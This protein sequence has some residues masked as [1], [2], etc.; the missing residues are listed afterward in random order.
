MHP[1]AQA[2]CL[3]LL[4]AAWANALPKVGRYTPVCGTDFLNFKNLT[5]PFRVGSSCPINGEC[6]KP[7][8]RDA[9][10]QKDLTIR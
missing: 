3:L 2:A 9:A 10:S 4:L 5:S 8:V 1:W 7:E 6:D